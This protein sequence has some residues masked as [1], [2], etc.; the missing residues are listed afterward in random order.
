M[1]KIIICDVKLK[2]SKFISKETRIDDDCIEFAC[3]NFCNFF[4]LKWLCTQSNCRTQHHNGFFVL[5]GT[6]QLLITENQNHF[7]PFQQIQ[8][9][10]SKN[11]PSEPSRIR[12]KGPHPSVAAL[13][14]GDNHLTEPRQ[15]ER[16]HSRHNP[17]TVTQPH[18]VAPPTINRR[19]VKQIRCPL[20]VQTIFYI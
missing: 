16:Y 20:I 12:T 15:L 10:G 3:S 5:P 11:L 14:N 1:S 6:L 8:N 19:P 18:I 9:V 4:P 2:I 7:D 13:L 17:R